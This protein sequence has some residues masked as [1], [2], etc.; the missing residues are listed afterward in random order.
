MQAALDLSW[1]RLQRWNG[2]SS[3]DFEFAVI[4]YR[5]FIKQS[6]VLSQ[7]IH[8]TRASNGRRG[9]SAAQLRLGL[10]LQLPL[11]L[12][13]PRLLISLL[14]LPLMILRR[15]K[16]VHLRGVGPVRCLC[17]VVVLRWRLRAYLRCPLLVLLNLLNLLNLLLRMLLGMLPPAVICDVSTL[18]TQCC[19]QTCKAGLCFC[20]LCANLS[21]P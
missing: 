5:M 18:C 12:E 7:C 9:H 8:T 17:C 11:P 1:A 10:L 6:L 13:Y 3:G 19:V 4:A 14:L 16:M 21:Q 20:F 2:C 15:V